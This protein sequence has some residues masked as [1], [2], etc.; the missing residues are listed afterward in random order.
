[1]TEIEK[2]SSNVSYDEHSGNLIWNVSKNSHGGRV[3][4]GDIAGFDRLD[5]YVGVRICG[6]AY[7]AHRVAWLLKT[8]AWPTAEVDHINGNRKDNTWSNLRQAT[9]RQNKFNTC[10]RS[11][12]KSGYKGVSWAKSANK[13]TA[14]I[15]DGDKYKYL[16]VFSDINDAVAAYKYA[17]QKIHGEFA[18]RD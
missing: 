6:K 8:G 15:K 9:S 11:D 10:I 16:G 4:V 2:I 12:N 7:L 1:M 14:R 13:W 5:G 3:I 18:R 17:S